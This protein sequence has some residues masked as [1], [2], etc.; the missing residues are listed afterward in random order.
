MSDAPDTL[1]YARLARVTEGLV[2][3][4]KRLGE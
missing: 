3:V 2:A 1:D 4:V